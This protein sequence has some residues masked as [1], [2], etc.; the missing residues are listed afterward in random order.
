MEKGTT[1][2]VRPR[3]DPPVEIEHLGLE[4]RG[5]TPVVGG[6]GIDLV[7][8]GD[9]GAVLDPG[10]VGGV[11]QRQ[12]AVG[13]LGVVQALERAAVDQL[14]AQA[15]V[16]L[17]AAVAPVDVRWLRRRPSSARPSRSASGCWWFLPLSLLLS[18]SVPAGIRWRS[19]RRRSSGSCSGCRLGPSGASPVPGSAWPAKSGVPMSDLG[20]E[21]ES[22]G[23]AVRRQ[24]EGDPLTLAEHSE[25][26]TLECVVRQPVL[27]RSMSRQEASVAGR[28]VV[29]LDDALH[30]GRSCGVGRLRVR[31]PDACRCSGCAAICA[32][33]P[34]VNGV[35][36]SDQRVTNLPFVPDKAT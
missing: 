22:G 16:L 14:L 17:C 34:L 20:A 9:E 8:A 21:T 4:L 15:V 12:V 24:F 19:V 29:G 30:L 28:R 6:A 2:M 33:D 26:G 36:I 31:A 32:V 1:Y 35:T 7:L 18:P 5:G 10:H 25:D 13:A 27:A 11:R 23:Q 3:I